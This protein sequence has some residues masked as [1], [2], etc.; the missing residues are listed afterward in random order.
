LVRATIEDFLKPH[1]KYDIRKLDLM[2]INAIEIL[3]SISQFAPSASLRT[4]VLCEDQRQK[5][6]PFIK[7]LTSHLLFSFEQG[8]KVQI[9]EFFKVLLDNDQTEKKVEFNDIFY[10][11]VLSAFINFLTTIE[12]LKINEEDD[13]PTVVLPGRPLPLQGDTPTLRS[14]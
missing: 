13:A 2:K 7:R 4:F 10:K 14:I 8:I 6:Y 5:G 11:E 3:M 9:F 1:D 12:D